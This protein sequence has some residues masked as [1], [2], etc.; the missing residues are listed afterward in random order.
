MM[1]LG[2]FSAPV[3]SSYMVWLEMCAAVV[4][5]W[6]WMYYFM[7]H[8]YYA[9]KAYSTGGHS[10]PQSPARRAILSWII[11]ATRWWKSSR[12]V[13]IYTITTQLSLTYSNTVWTSDFYIINC[14]HTTAPVFFSTFAAISLYC[15]D[16][17]L[18]W[19][20]ADQLLLLYSTVRPR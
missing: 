4:C 1:G 20:R 5:C 18:F 15:W 2:I 8:R 6:I 9:S 12:T 16:F 19:Y 7:G 17:L 13:N 11:L 3:H 14:A 10:H